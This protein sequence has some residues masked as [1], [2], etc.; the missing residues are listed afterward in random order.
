MRDM[1]REKKR[2]YDQQILINLLQ[3]ARLS[4]TPVGLT[5]RIMESLP[6]RMGCETVWNIFF[7]K[8]I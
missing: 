5:N 8:G 6:L 4:E 3:K 2:E 1:M 7:K